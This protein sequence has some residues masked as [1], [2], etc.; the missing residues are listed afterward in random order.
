MSAELLIISITGAIAL[1]TYIVKHCKG[2]ECW[3]KDNCCKIKMDIVSETPI[4]PTPP[5][6]PVE[7]THIK[8]SSIV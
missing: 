5:P 4:P 7:P 1:L 6:S 8:I 2:S 3:S